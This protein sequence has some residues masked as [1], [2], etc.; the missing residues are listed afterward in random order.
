MAYTLAT[1]VANAIYSVRTTL[2][3]HLSEQVRKVSRLRNGG[4]AGENLQAAMQAFEA[5]T[6]AA[7]VNATASIVVAV[8]GASQTKGTDKFSMVVLSLVLGFERAHPLNAAKT[9]T[10]AFLIPAPADAIID[11]NGRP[12]YTR[13][14]TFT[15]ASGPAEILGSLIDWLED[16]MVYEA[17]DGSVTVGGWTFVD[18][19]SG[20]ISSASVLEGVAGT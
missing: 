18:G 8:S 11:D 15:N 12:V 19:R 9:I 20:L 13:G 1:D 6:D 10:T 16:N 7:L 3:D 14:E 17:I 4:G 5:L 2:E